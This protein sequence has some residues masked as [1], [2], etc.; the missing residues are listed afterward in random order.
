MG[1]DVL[2]VLLCPLL[3]LQMGVD[4]A[5]VFCTP[6]AAPVIKGYS[7]E[8]IVMPMLPESQVS[9]SLVH[10]LQHRRVWGCI[11]HHSRV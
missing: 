8:L 11:V 6:S 10:H 1:V 9:Q 3:L 4:L 2:H 5:Y 7:P